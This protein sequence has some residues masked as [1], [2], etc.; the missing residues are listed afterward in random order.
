[1]NLFK[2][3]YFH[4]HTV[5]FM[6]CRSKTSSFGTFVSSILSLWMAYV[7][8]LWRVHLGTPRLSRR[9]LDVITKQFPGL[10]ASAT[11]IIMQYLWIRR[12]TQIRCENKCLMSKFINI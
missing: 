9:C 2:F 11:T 1:M 8:L 7:S 3:N 10:S 6:I 4:T 12:P 5:R